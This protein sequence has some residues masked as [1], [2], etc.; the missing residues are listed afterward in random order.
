[1]PSKCSSVTFFSGVIR[2]RAN[3]AILKSMFT[4]YRIM[5][6]Q[7]AKIMPANWKAAKTKNLI[8]RGASHIHQHVMKTNRIPV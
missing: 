7:N 4:K 2:S 5:N 3:I 6:A 8:G 1:M